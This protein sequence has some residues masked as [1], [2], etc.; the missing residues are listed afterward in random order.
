MTPL[1]TAEAPKP[2]TGASAATSTEPIA[3]QVA[4]VS[5]RSL[6]RGAPAGF[7]PRALATS[8][9]VHGVVLV[10]FVGW[11]DRFPGGPPREVLAAELHMERTATPLFNED[12][13]ESEPEWT[14]EVL[15]AELPDAF[16][17]ELVE[18]FVL[19]PEPLPERA[20]IERDRPFERVPLDAF[21]PP[22]PSEVADVVDVADVQDEAPPVEPPAEPIDETLVVGM[23]EMAPVLI[24]GPAPVYPPLALRQGWEGSSLVRI[25]V[26]ADGTVADAALEETSGYD[27]LD[28]AALKAIR[29]WRFE[30]GTLGGLVR[31]ADLL[32][33]VRFRLVDAR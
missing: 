19:D 25:T 18:D 14:L 20:S 21:A 1:S 24:D 31:E 3:R 5:A 15:P 28:D 8:F 10:G 29:A 23:Q 12:E 13:T 22:E 16:D 17:A 32:H 4:K 2:S 6:R 27:L 26:A 9:F 7:L 33:R 30:P 11:S